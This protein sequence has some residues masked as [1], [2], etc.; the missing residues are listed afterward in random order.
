MFNSDR[1]FPDFLR[2]RVRSILLPALL[3]SVVYLVDVRALL[4]GAYSPDFWRRTC[5]G[6][7]FSGGG[8]GDVLWFLYVNFLASIPL[9]AVTRA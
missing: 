9:Y 3:F 4:S 5:R 7:C 1:P 8:E 6:C 2:R